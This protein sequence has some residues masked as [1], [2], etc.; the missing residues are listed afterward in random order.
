MSRSLS[1]LVSR[2]M[3][4]SAI[5]VVSLAGAPFLIA[6][7]FVVQ[8]HLPFSVILQRGLNTSLAFG[9]VGIMQLVQMT[10][11][12]E[13]AGGGFLFL[14][15]LPVNDSE[16]VSS[17]L[18]AILLGVLI[19]CGVP[20][21]ATSGAM[22]YYHVGFPAGFWFDVAWVC[23]AFAA[24]AVGMTAC[25]IQFDS[26]RAALFPP[27]A[28]GVLLCLGALAWTHFPALIGWM[29]RA[30]IQNWGLVVA[31]ASIWLGWRGTI[32]LFSK[33]DFVELSE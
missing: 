10:I 29:G 6:G 32:H 18:L 15:M 28:F 23:V 25:A 5:F 33:R 12:K 21:M 22:I 24:L 11:S 27:L 8:S 26:Q 14:R 2:E 19:I 7:F 9:A 1:T 4:Q 13:K 16:I 20:L 3:R 17:K 30:G 31:V